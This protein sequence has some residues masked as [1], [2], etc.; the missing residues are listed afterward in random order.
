[1]RK[2]QFTYII[3]PNEQSKNRRISLLLL[4]LFLSCLSAH[5]LRFEL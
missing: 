2:Q 4:L 3:Y 5:G 1:M